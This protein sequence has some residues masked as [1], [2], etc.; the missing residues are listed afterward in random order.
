[1]SELKL[2]FEQMV[3]ELE[4]GITD[5]D[6]A[7]A[8]F[9][10]ASQIA[11]QILDVCKARGIEPLSPVTDM[12]SEEGQMCAWAALFYKLGT[13]L[14]DVDTVCVMYTSARL[15]RRFRNAFKPLQELF[16]KVKEKGI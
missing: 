1:M 11:K 2:L 6:Y 9:K 7:V 15:C 16:N 10:A 13:K 14:Y 12:T 5:F 8:H 3:T 4:R